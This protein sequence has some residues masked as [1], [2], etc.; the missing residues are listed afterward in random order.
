MS[1][2]LPQRPDSLT[3]GC[4]CGAVRYAVSEKPLATGLCHCNRC[5]P[6]SGSAFSTV[7]FVHS[8]AIRITGETAVFDDI[9][10]SGLRVRRRYCPRCGSPLTTESDATPG[11]FFIKAGSIDVNEWFHPDMEMFVRGRR[12]WVSPVP[13]A[14]Q[15]DGNP[16]F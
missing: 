16:T 5:R 15:F 3:G 10:A 6:Q 14:V 8:D 1:D 7:I 11:I 4:M 13:G 9:G 2:D 12:P